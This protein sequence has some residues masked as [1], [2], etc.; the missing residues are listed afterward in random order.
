[1]RIPTKN[2]MFCEESVGGLALSVKS[3]SSRVRWQVKAPAQGAC[4][5]ALLPDHPGANKIAARDP[6]AR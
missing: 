2:N 4:A 5:L 3:L 1:M 6:A